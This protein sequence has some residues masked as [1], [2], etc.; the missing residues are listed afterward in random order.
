[1]TI[2]KIF[3][4]I[5]KEELP[6]I[7]K[8]LITKKFKLQKFRKNEIIIKEN[9]DC[10][11]IFFVLKG[12]IRIFYFNI[13]G[14]EVTRTFIFE[15][16]F[17]TNLI[18]F[19]GQAPNNENIQ[20]LEDTLVFSIFREDFYDMLHQSHI[21]TQL[22]YK[23]L[24][25]FINRHLQH[26]QFMNTLNERQ[27]IEKFLQTSSHINLRVKDKIIATYLGVTPEYLSKTKSKTIKN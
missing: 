21:L 20:C 15:N 23:I 4:H 12:A 8:E 25:L 19:S 13:L 11:R 10:D 7:E 16:E 6:D 1:M 14:T 2:E 9:E 18:S 5:S 27:R 24:E 3:E 26:F 22:Y 17:C